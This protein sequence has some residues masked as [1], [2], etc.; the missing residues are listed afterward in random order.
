MVL[1]LL[2]LQNNNIMAASQNNITCTNNTFTLSV[3]TQ[4]EVEYLIAYKTDTTIE[5]VTGSDQM[6][7]TFKKEIYAGTCSADVCQPHSVIRGI[8]K[9]YTNKKSH[10]NNFLVPQ[11]YAASP[12]VTTQYFT[13][14]KNSIKT[15]TYTQSTQLDLTQQDEQWLEDPSTVDIQNTQDEN[16]ENPTLP[17]TCGL[18][19]V[20]VID[21]SG[22]INNSELHQMKDAF[23][24][25]VDAFV[26]GTPTQI[27]VVDFDNEARI[28]QDFS[29]N[30]DTIKNAINTPESGGWTNWQDA[31]ETSH[32][33]TFPRPTKPDLIVFASDGNPT[34]P[35]NQSKKDENVQAAVEAANAIKKD[36]I[37]ILTLG[38]GNDLSTENLQAI[39]GDKVDTGNIN[40]DVITTDFETLAQDLSE[41]S[42]G[43]CA[44]KLIV[45]KQLD[46]NKD[47]DVEDS[48]DFDGSNEDTL[49][50]NWEFALTGST[51]KTMTTDKSGVIEFQ[52]DPGNYNLMEI[53]N[54]NYIFQTASCLQADNTVGELQNTGIHNIEMGFE[55][56]ITCTVINEP[57]KM[58]VYESSIYIEKENDTQGENRYA[59]DIVTYTITITAQEAMDD[60]EMIDELPEGFTYIS[61]SWTAH[62]NI[63]GN[64]SVPEPNYTSPGTWY[65]GDMQQNEVI[66]LTLQAQIHDEQNPGIYKDQSYATGTNQYEELVYANG[67]ENRYVSTQV[68]VVEKQQNTHNN[69]NNTD[70]QDID[71]Q[72]E[73]T[74]HNEKTNNKD[75]NN[76]SSNSKSP[77]ESSRIDGKVLGIMTELP[78]TGGNIIQY[79]LALSLIIGGGSLLITDNML[80]KQKQ[81]RKK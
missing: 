81:S 13:I 15:T 53:V 54:K 68:A 33:L 56:T 69:N 17:D 58:P 39:S 43:L 11:I 14:S 78:V 66:T 38:I 45:Q 9:T 67:Y 27:A 64:I 71:N 6:S 74:D 3:A 28:L 52:L 12:N 79:L 10:A 37:R 8:V 1:S 76:T 46:M 55:Q 24:N 30:A 18:D 41:F 50:S 51:T 2:T 49:L 44:G 21:S 65:V 36:N 48:R 61:G 31:L 19:M 72:N 73:H 35:F 80:K 29:N 22:S 20:L 42:K 40:T 70:S 32:S 5:V 23:K 25:F 63:H 4:N 62:S 16:I 77:Q 7:P 26:P 34:R 60:I 47:G 75:D 57:E 59:G